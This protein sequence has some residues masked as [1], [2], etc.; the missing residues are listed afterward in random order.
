MIHTQHSAPGLIRSACI[1]GAVLLS[2]A[3]VTKGR[4]DESTAQVKYYQ[5]LYQ[6]LEAFQGQLEAEN[7]LLR[8]ELDIYRQS[9]P[10]EAGVTEVIDARMRE[11]E[12]IA[13]SIGGTLGQVDV[14]EVEGGY[15]LRLADSVLFESGSAQVRPEGAELLQRMAREIT[16][17][18]F[19]RVYVRGHTDSDP[20]KKPETR[21][22]FPHGNLQLSA[23]RATEVCAAMMQNGIDESL[24]VVVGF[25]A[26][27]PVVPNDSAEN[28]TRNRRVEIF[29]IEDQEA[30]SEQR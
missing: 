16:S 13:E 9:G 17:R 21:R 29:V 24:L 27:E 11:L 10:I 14:L 7:E 19:Q 23:A 2:S 4:Y 30:A 25:G 18:P 28:K 15:G 20:V 6:D 8:G 26:N 12:R 3:C 5:S 1:A 22:M